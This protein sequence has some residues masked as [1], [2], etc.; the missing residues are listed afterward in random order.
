MKIRTGDHVAHGPTG[1]TW[2]VAHVDGD[3]LAWCGW[4]SG[5]AMLED[6]VLIRRSTDDEHLSL[7]QELAKSSDGKRSSR[8]RAA[9][10]ALSASTT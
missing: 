9:L 8:A 3:R 10:E 4:P 5:E 6:C 7:L 1:E 2:V